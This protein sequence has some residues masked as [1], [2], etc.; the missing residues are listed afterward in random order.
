M[1]GQKTSLKNIA[2]PFQKQNINQIKMNIFNL[3]K[4]PK[5][6]SG[7]LKDDRK[8]EE[9]RKDYRTEE[10]IATASP[11]SY[12]TWEFWKDMKTNIKMLADIKV[13]NQK[14][15]YSCEGQ[16]ISLALAI[17][18][19]IEDGMFIKY[20]VDP[21][22]AM[23]RNSPDYG[24]YADDGGKLATTTA[25]IPEVLY[26]SHNDS[27]EEM[28]N[29]DNYISAF[30]AIGKI[31]RA[32]N[33]F[34]LYKTTNI[35]SFAQVSAMGKP[36]VMTV[37]FGDGEF[38]TIAPEVKAVVP[39]YG[40]AITIL[41]NSYFTYKG[42]KAVLI[43]NSW[44]DSRYYG[45][46][47]ILTEDWFINNRIVC[48]M[49]FEDMNNLAVFNSQ[50]EKISHNFTSDLCYGMN[51]GEVRVLQKCLATEKDDEGFLFPV[52]QTCTGYFGGITLQAVKRFQR[53][54]KIEPVLGYCGPLTRAKLNKIFN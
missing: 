32:K 50:M 49:W 12:P 53:K 46:R 47:Q 5:L 34:W 11:L 52:Y 14:N 4:K 26:P 17:N 36:I 19:Y 42:K 21:I 44:G 54:Y 23:R 25:T 7:V 48:G 18:N 43:Q 29:L 38:G 30:Q 2:T 20:S 10:I 37:L 3:F 9:K 13:N 45:G 24:M 8:F 27:E 28:N 31:L 15:S 22:Y 6:I 39:K 1:V 33:Y 41:P 51:N 35:D 40:H 16:A